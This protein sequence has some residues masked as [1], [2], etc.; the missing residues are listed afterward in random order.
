MNRSLPVRSSPSQWSARSQ[1]LRLSLSVAGLAALIAL[2]ASQKVLQAQTADAMTESA[3]AS[4][5]TISPATPEVVPSSI[6]APQPPLPVSPQSIEPAP[7]IDYSAPP[8]VA[9]SA[10]PNEPFIDATDYSLG[11]THRSRD[12][13]ATA[14]SIVSRGVQLPAASLSSVQIGPLSVVSSGIGIGSLPSVKEFYR[15]TLPPLG[16]LGNG[17]IRLIF[18]LSIPAPITSVFG[19]R[20]HPI[21]GDPRFHMGTD[22]GAPLGTPVL[23]AYAGR[24]AIADF[25]GGYGLAIVLDHNKGTQQ[26]LYG[27]LSEIFVKQGELVKQGSVIG[28]VG[29]TGNSTGAHLHFEF[30]QLTPDGWVALDPGSQLEYALAELVKV[31]AVSEKGIA[32]AK[33]MPISR[34]GQVGASGEINWNEPQQ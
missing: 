11:A 30:R 29:S 3:P 12:L 32:I 33:G 14:S 13:P 17:N 34:Q 23:A 10:T 9:P 31:L 7:P 8:A 6:P 15:R 5:D 24:V 22:L 20:I 21:S 16:R 2:G 26:T 25:L 28:R 18:P 1:R 27:H 4:V 19:W